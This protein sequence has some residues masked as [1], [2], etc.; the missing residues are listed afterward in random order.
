[1][2]DLKLSVVIP[3]HNEIGNIL[4]VL[5]AL[6]LALKDA[7][8]PY[9]IVVV[10]DNS[11]DGTAQAVEGFARDDSSVRLINRVPPSGF[12]RAIRAGLE[13]VTGDVVVLFM[14]DESDDPKDVLS[15]YYKIL[16]GYD[17]VFGSR[18]I[19]GSEVRDYPRVKLVCNRI[20]NRLIQ[21]LFWTSHNDLTNA[22]KA[23]RT[24]VIREC[25]PYRACHFNITIEMSISALIRG[26]SIAKVPIHWYG[27]EWGSSNLGLRVMGRRYLASLLKLFFER[28]LIHDDLMAE[29]RA[30]RLKSE[31]SQAELTD[32]IR[33]LEGRLLAMEN[34]T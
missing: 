14:G 3:A 25:E 26:Y 31:R 7:L 15:Y 6:S 17:C 5:S 27:R 18:F 19:R 29:R 13:F 12:G 11:T 10:N 4:K 24:Y 32:R 16:E 20:I 21:I 23:Y 22:F 33:E 2:K 30:F 28:L 8:I 34:R 9:E 1:M